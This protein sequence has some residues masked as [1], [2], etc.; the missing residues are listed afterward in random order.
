MP[1]WSLSNTS[2][3]CI[4]TF[5]HLGTLDSTLALCLGDSLAAKINKK[6]QNMK[7]EVLNRP[8]KGYI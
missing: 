3:F 8:Q 7:T 1:E 4:T 2:I 5:L 6:H